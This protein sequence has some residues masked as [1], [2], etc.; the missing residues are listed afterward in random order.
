MN[1]YKLI[2]DAS[3]MIGMEIIDEKLKIIGLPIVNAV[4][5]ELGFCPLKT[6]SDGVGVY[7]RPA[8][9]ALVFGTAMLICNALGDDEGRASMSGLYNQKLSLLRGSV[10][11]VRD[12]QPKGDWV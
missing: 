1:G 4:L 6:L 8:R 2:S 5:E 3:K 12:T 9:Q 7:S 11:K 10:A